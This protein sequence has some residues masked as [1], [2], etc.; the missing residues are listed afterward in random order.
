MI[1]PEAP[2]IALFLILTLALLIPELFR[3]FHFPFVTII[4]LAGAVA[5]P[6][7]LGYI[8]PNETVSFFGFL[9]MIFL[10][11][12][13]GLETKLSKLYE[14][15]KKVLIL[16]TLN[17]LVPF[18]IGFFITYFFGYDL[19]ASTV[20]G[21]I[22]TSSAVAIILPAMKGTKIVETN[23]W[24]VM[25]AS[26]VVVDTLSLIILGTVLH[27]VSP[28]NNVPM[29]MFIVI[30]LA[31]ITLLFFITPPLSKF[32]LKS[33][34]TSEASHENQL[35]FVIVFTI[36]ALVFFS[37]L[38][39]HPILAA[40]VTGLSLSRAL[41]K[42]RSKIIDTKLHTIGYGLF[43]PIF[44]FIVG[45]EMDLKVLGQFSPANL[46]MAA[47]VLG[48]VITK[49]LTGYIGG[50]I[51]K[52][53]RKHSLLFGTLSMTQLTATLAV[54]YAAGATGFFDTTLVNTGI[55]LTIVTAFLGPYLGTFI[56]R[57]KSF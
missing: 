13:A 24:Q 23:V 31:S 34:K 57:R 48:L 10:L 3:R 35:M 50:R 38:G 43:I 5:G 9:G 6:N 14:D 32:I 4:L 25:I 20:I 29:G 37:W 19:R 54:T 16:V 7:G 18:I 36:G 53:S 49:T 30:L 44:L 46:V 41:P 42:E 55:I 40:F 47:I 17:G 21:A 22:F 28:S 15:K 12:M 52:F 33:K 27:S 8:S 11:L 26:I 1:A 56:E 45:M 39:I 51:I 2:L